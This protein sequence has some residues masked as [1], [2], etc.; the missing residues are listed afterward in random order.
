M[1][2]EIWKWVHIREAFL[3]T[4]VELKEYP[5]TA[6]SKTA[7]LVSLLQTY[8]SVLNMTLLGCPDLVRSKQ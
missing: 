7:V 1:I 3:S 4:T 5:R 8:H 2:S 6:F